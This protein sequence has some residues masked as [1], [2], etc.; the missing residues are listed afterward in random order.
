MEVMGQ[1]ADLVTKT[2]NKMLEAINERF[3]VVDSFIEE[4][5]KTGEKFY[6]SFMEL[7]IQF[8]N[9]Q[10]LFEFMTYYTPTVVEVLEPYNLNISA[11]E[12]ENICN[13]VLSKIHEFD[14]K[15]KTTMSVNELLSQKVGQSNTKDKV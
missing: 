15:L 14:K 13:D 9:V 2:L 8:K 11:G 10:K 6:N 7:T 4:P 1:P 12:L 5:E 3:K